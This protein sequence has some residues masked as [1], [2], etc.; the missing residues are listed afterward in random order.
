MPS[1]C[2]YLT[3]PRDK[4]W[5]WYSVFKEF[6]V[7][8]FSSFQPRMSHLREFLLLVSILWHSI[9]S[10]SS[11]IPWCSASDISSL[12]FVYPSKYCTHTHTHIQTH[13]CYGPFCWAPYFCWPSDRRTEHNTPYTF[14]LAAW[15]IIVDT[16]SIF[17]VFIGWASYTITF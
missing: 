17:K 7:I 11:K 13:S 16:C 12:S 8:K 9:Y 14:L 4:W 3:F 15:F 5:N 6:A 2:F 10:D 1:L